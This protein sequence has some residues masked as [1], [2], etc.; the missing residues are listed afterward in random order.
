MSCKHGKHPQVHYPRSVKSQGLFT[1]LENKLIA[2]VVLATAI[3]TPNVVWDSVNLPKVIA[4]SAG[5]FGLIFVS[6]ISFGSKSFFVNDRTF[7]RLVFSIFISLI[8]VLFFSGS[9]FSRSLYGTSGRN[10]G[11]LTY[12]SCLILLYVT[13][14]VTM[15]D[16][17]RKI[18]ITLCALGAFSSAYGLIQWKNLDPI[19]WQNKY[20]PVI[21]FFGNPNFISGFLGIA[22]IASVTFAFSTEIKWAGRLMH[23]GLVII[24][25]AVI[26]LSAS[27]QGFFI[28]FAGVIMV[29]ILSSLQSRK[30]P[31]IMVTLGLGL[32]AVIGFG[33]ALIGVKPFTFLESD[34]GLS[35]RKI[36]WKAAIEMTNAKPFLGVGYD[37][38]ID[39]FR[40]FRPDSAF[41][42]NMVNIY[43]DSAHNIFLDISTSGGYPLFI[44]Y[45]VLQ[46]SI[47]VSIV[48]LLRRY[49]PMNS[50]FIA[51]IG[52]WVGY[53]VYSIVSI[54]QIGVMLWGWVFGGLIIGYEINTR[55]ET[56][57]IPRNEKIDSRSKNLPVKPAHDYFNHL[58]FLGALIGG[59]IALP[60]YINSANYVNALQSGN[61]DNIKSAAVRWPVEEQRLVG[62]IDLLVANK[63]NKDALEVAHEALN[64]FPNSSFI[65]ESLAR[66]PEITK[67]ELTK[68]KFELRKLD[69]RN[70]NL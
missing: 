48:K 33:F 8:I 28:L 13:A 46:L 5:T 41:E 10:T 61:L 54:N 47:V 32:S 45:A 19:N 4:L 17:L 18:T 49:S 70:P 38:Y 59:L 15:I 55:T 53:Q 37:G 52:S 58:F 25:I 7:N 3:I 11:F 9:N 31:R 63:L 69:P 39:W 21:G 62:T 42:G 24:E 43:S 60:I 51:I 30:K 36:F 68:A 12:I 20:G 22:A 40:K 29:M 44:L 6:F 16:T 34:S 14:R 66:I 67:P 2:V 65:W 23:A 64:N 56:D 27:S 50:Y 1:R 35:V 57:Q 26:K